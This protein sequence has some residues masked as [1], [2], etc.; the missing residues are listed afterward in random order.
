MADQDE[1]ISKQNEITDD[2][3][4]TEMDQNETMNTTPLPTILYIAVETPDPTSGDLYETTSP[5]P[6]N[7]SNLSSIKFDKSQMVPDIS[8]NDPL[9]HPTSESE[10]KDRFEAS[11]ESRKQYD[12]QLSWR[13]HN[14]TSIPSGSMLK[15]STIT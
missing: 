10:L 9:K 14:L 11:D 4:E 5:C 12:Q 13:E 3:V 8:L 6:A 15:L 2:K 7:S 1:I